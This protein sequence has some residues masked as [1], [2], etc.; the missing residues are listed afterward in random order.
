MSLGIRSPEALLLFRKAQFADASHLPRGPFNGR[1][2]R[3]E[4]RE[5]LDRINRIVCGCPA[6]FLYRIE[7]RMTWGGS[8]ELEFDADPELKNL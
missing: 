7:R 1:N 3:T 6:D 5:N 4:W 8:E 2:E